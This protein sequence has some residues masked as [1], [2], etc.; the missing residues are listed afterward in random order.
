MGLSGTFATMHARYIN[1]VPLL[2]FAALF[3]YACYAATVVGHW[4][5]YSFPDPSDLPAEHLGAP[6]VLVSL[7]SFALVLLI[8]VAYLIYRILA[9]VRKWELREQKGAYVWYA[10]GAAPW[11][12]DLAIAGASRYSLISWILD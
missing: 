9:R 7:L 6:L 8:P 1:L 12:L 10:V 11:L 4:P 3:G 2:G 5:Y